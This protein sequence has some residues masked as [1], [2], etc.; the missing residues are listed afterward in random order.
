MNQLAVVRSA[1]PLTVSFYGDL[2][3]VPI[4]LVLG[5]YEPQVQDL[6]L[7]QE[8]ASAQW[9]VMGKVVSP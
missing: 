4:S 7:M 3:T 9:M 8:I 6:V 1:N 2:A 5:D